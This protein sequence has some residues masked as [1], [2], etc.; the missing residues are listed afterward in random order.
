[1]VPALPP[2]IYNGSI[3]LSGLALPLF[4]SL[5]EGQGYQEASAHVGMVGYCAGVT[6]GAFLGAFLLPVLTAKIRGFRP[7][8]T[9]PLMKP[10][11][12]VALPL[13]LGQTII[14]LDEQLLRIFGSLLSEGSVSLLTYARRISQVPV[15]LVGQAAAVASYPFLVRLVTEG[16]TAAM[17]DTVTG[18][19]RTTLCLSIPCAAYLAATAWSVITLLF[20][21]GRFG[22]AECVASVPILRI[23][24]AGV[25]VLI[26]Y[27]ILARA[28][29]AHENTLTPALTGTLCTLLALPVYWYVSQYGSPAGLALTSV[30]AITVY[31]LWLFV[32][33]NRRYTKL[34][35]LMLHAVRV[36]ACTIPAA[37]L[38]WFAHAYLAENAGFH[39]VITAL[40]CQAVASVLFLLAFLTLAGILLPD[41]VARLR[42]KLSG[43]KRSRKRTEP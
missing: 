23:L 24:L 21:G 5:A 20:Y 32:L 38:A 27:M 2:L 26:F 4:V 15:G 11:C 19:L 42:A 35:G 1:R 16:D 8:F 17:R 22:M 14:M 28:Y 41:Q 33:W 30:C 25:P 3:I 43:L 6:I 31:V 34:S 36:L 39:P 7:R 18:A 12:L 13:M 9:H 10:F 40:L 29:Y 37:L